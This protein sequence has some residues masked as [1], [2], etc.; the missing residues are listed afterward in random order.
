MSTTI[1]INLPNYGAML[2]SVDEVRKIAIF[3]NIPYAIIP[4][5]WRAAV[6]PQPWTGVRDATKQGPVCP[7]TTSQYP[8]NVIVPEEQCKIGNNRKYQFGLDHDEF[9]CLNL[10]IY[11]PLDSLREQ[12]LTKP[13]PVMVWIHGGGCREGSNGDPLYDATNIVKRSIELNQPVIVVCM[14]YRLNCFGFL[15]SKELEQEMQEHT[16]SSSEPVSKYN[17]SIGNWGLMD[18]KL[19]FKWVREN[20]Q[21]FGG[22]PRNVTAF[23]ESAGSISIHYHMLCPAHFGLFDR[24]IM[25]SGTVTTL[26]AAHVLTDGQAIFDGILKNLNIPLD[27]D[28]PEKMRRLRAIPFDALAAAGGNHTTFPG[29]QPYYDPNHKNTILPAKVPIQVLCQDPNAYDPAL[30]SVFIGVN[31]D[32]G[33]AFATSLHGSCNLETWPGLRQKFVPV[34]ELNPLFE[35]EFQ[36][37]LP[38]K[39]D[40]DVFQIVSKYTGDHMMQYPIYKAS[41]ALLTLQDQKPDQFRVD[42]YHFDTDIQRMNDL[43]PGMGALHVAEIPYVFQPPALEAVLTKE[44]LDFSREMQDLWIT[45]AHQMPLSVEGRIPKV[46]EAIIFTKDYQIQI[47]E[48]VRLSKDALAFWSKNEERAAQKC[49]AQLLLRKN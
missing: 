46:N 33:T 36:K 49:Q 28:G 23:G 21:A 32:E 34:P 41:E 15:A 6:K 39:T 26:P 9:N 4:E 18:Q 40:S 7:Q 12:A 5:R 3:R 44:E 37:M 47:G 25:H 27:L 11:V 19:A 43:I 2:G 16:T 29:F 48:G 13:V 42:R 17:Q 30:Q 8:L 35:A 14:N 22:Q 45:F 31:K 38:P 20:I 10:N 24:A 1:E